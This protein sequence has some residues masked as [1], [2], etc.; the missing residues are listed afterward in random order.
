[1]F[2]WHQL[3]ID[4]YQYVKKKHEMAESNANANLTIMKKTQNQITQ[5]FDF[6]LMD[7]QSSFL[8]NHP[9]T[10]VYSKLKLR[11]C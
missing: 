10:S 9:S 1:M 5:S 7:I 6:I 3:H 4:T 2:C 8:Y 11:L